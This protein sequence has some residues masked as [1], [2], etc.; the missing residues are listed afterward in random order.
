MMTYDPDYFSETLAF[1]SGTYKIEES[2]RRR[3]RTNNVPANRNM[4]TG[5]NATVGISDGPEQRTYKGK[6][7]RPPKYW[8]DT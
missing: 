1:D 4:N 8:I 6:S 5:G 3:R 2:S 7:K